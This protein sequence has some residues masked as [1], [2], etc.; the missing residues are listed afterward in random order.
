M[1]KK[2]SHTQK[3]KLQIRHAKNRIDIIEMEIADLEKELFEEE[4]EEITWEDLQKYLEEN[5]KE[6]W[7]DNPAIRNFRGNHGFIHYCDIRDLKVHIGGYEHNDRFP[8]E[9]NLFIRKDRKSYY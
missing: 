9:K 3:L 1:K 8:R 4:W 5:P 7:K 2:H 6:H